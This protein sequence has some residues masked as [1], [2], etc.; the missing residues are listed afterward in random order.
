MTVFSGRGLAGMVVLH[1][2]LY[3]MILEVFSKLNDSTILW[4]WS[5]VQN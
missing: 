4:L 5:R 2:R 3:L 1:W